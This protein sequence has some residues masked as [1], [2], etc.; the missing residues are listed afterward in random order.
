[1]GLADKQ[2]VDN[3]DAV[4]EVDSFLVVLTVIFSLV[5]TWR[6]L[7]LI[8]LI[9]RISCLISIFHFYLIFFGKL[10]C[11]YPKGPAA[12]RVAPLTC[13]ARR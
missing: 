8:L 3:S 4:F 6:P 7:H 10:L 13:Q 5:F 1:M 9:V 12:G 2:A 11:L